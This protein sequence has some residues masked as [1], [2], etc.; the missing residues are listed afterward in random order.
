M[1]NFGG[2]D[3]DAPFGGQEVGAGLLVVVVGLELDVALEAAQAAGGGQLVLALGV[4]ALFLLAQG[5]AQAAVV[6]EAA[7][8]LFQEV[9]FLLALCG[10]F[11]LDV[12]A[13]GELQALV[14]HGLAALELDV[15]GAESGGLLRRGIQA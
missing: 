5:D 3:A 11:E 2:L 10:G 1:R 15:L 4:A 6:D 9:L 8:L 7:G 12:L 14:G 13:C